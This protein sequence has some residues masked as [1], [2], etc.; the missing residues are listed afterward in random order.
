MINLNDIGRYV[1]KSAESSYKTGFNC[2]SATMGK[3]PRY[4]VYH[5]A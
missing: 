1:Q 2:L 5:A 3:A 4:I